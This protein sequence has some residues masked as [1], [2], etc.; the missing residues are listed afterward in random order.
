VQGWASLPAPARRPPPPHPPDQ[1]LRVL[2]AAVPHPLQAACLTAT[3]TGASLPRSST[4]TGWPAGASPRG[5]GRE[6]PGAHGRARSVC[7]MRGS[8]C[9]MCAPLCRHKPPGRAGWMGTEGR[10]GSCVK[11]ARAGSR[12]AARCAARNYTV[13]L[14]A[15]HCGKRLWAF[16]GRSNRMQ[17]VLLAGPHGPPDRAPGGTAVRCVLCTIVYPCP[18]RPR[19]LPC[20]RQAAGARQAQHPWIQRDAS[21]GGGGN[22]LAAPLACA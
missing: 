2:H 18:H 17:A 15:A 9:V 10:Q 20:L 12:L 5:S 6:R 19:L 22:P 3:A 8:V 14:R 1:Q 7:V 4:R 13:P 21:R 16:L 11:E